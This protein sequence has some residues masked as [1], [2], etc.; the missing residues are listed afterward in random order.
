MELPYDLAT[1]L[2][3]TYGVWFLY[4]I[5]HN[6]K[7]N[8]NKNKIPFAGLILQTKVQV[9]RLPAFFSPPSPFIIWLPTYLSSLLH[10]ILP[11]TQYE[12][13]KLYLPPSLSYSPFPDMFLFST[14]QHLPCLLLDHCLSFPGMLR[15]RI[16]LP[17]PGSGASGKLPYPS[18]CCYS[19]SSITPHQQHRQHLVQY[20]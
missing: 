7:E 11:S 10:N 17:R 9:P 3:G 16:S 4:D 6:K 13:T 14:A 20:V 12:H 5:F 18:P 2:L 15:A 8:E 19:P 1:P